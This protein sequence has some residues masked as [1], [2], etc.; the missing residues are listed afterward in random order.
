MSVYFI[1]FALI[2]ALLIGY[3]CSILPKSVRKAFFFLAAAVL[4]FVAGFR[5]RVG[6]DYAIYQ[7]IYNTYRFEPLRLLSTPALNIVARIAGILY[8]D[9]ATWF[10]LMSV[11]TIVPVMKAIKDNSVWAAM[12]VL[13]YLLLGCWHFSFNIVKQCAAAAILLVGYPAL[14]DRAFLKWCLS[15]LLAATFHI[16][17]VLMIGMYFLVGPEITKKRT[18]LL[19]GVGLVILIA[20][21][22]LYELIAALKKGKSVVDE[23]SN[24][25]KDSVNILRILVNC[26]PVLLCG[27][28]FR[29]YDRKNK[30]FCCLFN[31]S[32]LNAMVNIGSMNSIYLNRFCI[33]T[34]LFNVLFVPMLFKP[35]WKKRYWWIIPL[36]LVLYFVFWVYDL[37]KDPATCQFYWVFNN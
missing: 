5:Y 1:T 6:T 8:D 10:F 11:I 13:M 32:L 33:Y 25:W 20:Y 29:E 15:C 14:R 28:F 4:I 27:L 2:C 37:Y 7:I 24:V 19:I 35:L 17:A 34:N 16:S 12:S 30:D 22:F 36:A 23:D 31:A 9:S 3:S 18:I 26:V 21:D